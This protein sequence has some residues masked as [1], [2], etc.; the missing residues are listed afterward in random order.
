MASNG[1]SNS[2]V[3]LKYLNKYIKNTTISEFKDGIKMSKCAF[4]N[5]KNDN[6][7]TISVQLPKIVISFLNVKENEDG[8]KKYELKFNLDSIENYSS[9]VKETFDDFCNKLTDILYNENE[10]QRNKI[11]RK[12]ISKEKIYEMLKSEKNF[13]IKEQREVDGKV[14]PS[15]LKT[16]LVLE[17]DQ[18]AKKHTNK[19]KC[20][21]LNNGDNKD[22]IHLTED[23]IQDIITYKSEAVPVIAPSQI[24]YSGDGLSVIWKV[25]KMKFYRNNQGG[26]SNQNVNF[27]EDSDDENENTTKEEPRNDNDNGNESEH[28]NYSLEQRSKNITLE[29]KES[30]SDND[31]DSDTE[32]PKKTPIRRKRKEV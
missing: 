28:S 17:Y 19:F 23:N 4:I 25:L 15:T 31:S 14:Y 3:K 26:S 6:N 13:F 24:W 8:K 1:N 11:F 10:K 2:I 20:I 30:D 16:R 5:L 12:K 27:A 29:E 22:I 21:V 32:L 18:D 9:V 7:E